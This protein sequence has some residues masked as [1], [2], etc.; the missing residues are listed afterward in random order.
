MISANDAHQPMRAEH[1]ESWQCFILQEILSWMT[2]VVMLIED[3]ICHIP[4]GLTSFKYIDHI[5]YEEGPLHE[6]YKAPGCRCAD[7]DRPAWLTAKS[8]AE[9]F[10]APTVSQAFLKLDSSIPMKMFPTCNDLDSLPLKSS[11]GICGYDPQVSCTL[12]LLR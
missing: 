12:T 8:K 2:S 11:L 10:C 6:N 3:Y 9:S 4:A 7:L 1:V 5:L